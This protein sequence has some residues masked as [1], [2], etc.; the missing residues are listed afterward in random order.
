MSIA[1]D[2]LAQLPHGAQPTRD[3]LLFEIG[4]A[5]APF[6]RAI[7]TGCSKDDRLVLRQLAEEGVINRQN[8]LAIAN[9]LRSG[10]VRRDPT[11]HIMNETFR[12]FI[13]E[14][15]SANE[16]AELEHEGVL[17]PWGS[18]TTMLLTGALFLIGVI[19]LTQQQLMDAWVGYVPMLAPA[20]PTVLK[21]L[22]SVQRDPKA[23][24]A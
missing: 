16:L 8:A 6:Y 15:L 5:A 11:F 21:L 14:E 9:L 3:A 1:T 4:V 10:L 12:R 24:T 20:V 23:A 17:L 19:L 18:I 2:V 13:L 22:G 7:W